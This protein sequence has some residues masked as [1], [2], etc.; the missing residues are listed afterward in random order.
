MQRPHQT[1]FLDPVNVTYL[2][3]L[4]GPVIVTWPKVTFLPSFVS[5][6]SYSKMILIKEKEN[7][8]HV[9]VISMLKLEK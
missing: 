7:T 4:H 1:H 2:E 6:N 3:S 8:K 9:S 5:K